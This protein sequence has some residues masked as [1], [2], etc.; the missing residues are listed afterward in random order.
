MINEHECT[1]ENTVILSLHKR[2]VGYE[3]EKKVISYISTTLELDFRLILSPHFA[4]L[5]LCNSVSFVIN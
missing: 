4:T 3:A 2:M 5:K 1:L